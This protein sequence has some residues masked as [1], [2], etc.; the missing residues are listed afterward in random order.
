MLPFITQYMLFTHSIADSSKLQF[1]EMHVAFHDMAETIS[2]AAVSNVESF[3]F[4]RVKL[5]EVKASQMRQLTGIEMFSWNPLITASQRSNW[6]SFVARESGWYNESKEFVINDDTH[7]LTH[8]SYT[9]NET[10]PSDV[11]QI[12]EDGSSGPV[13]ESAALL[14]PMWQMS[15]PPFSP[16]FIN[17][18]IM[19]EAFV[20]T[21]LSVMQRTRD[22]IMSALDSTLE[23]LA[24]RAVTPHDHEA[25]HLLY[26]DALQKNISSFDHPHSVHLQPVF[27][28]LQD[29]GSPLAG[30]LSFVVP[31]D[32]YLSNLLPATVEGVVA[33]LSNT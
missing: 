6:S 5:F 18:N 7:L 16:S 32:K 33:V 4:V 3:P 29:P 1:Q 22:G 28:K 11:W 13:D 2:A 14:A 25:F 31:W 30:F 21:M 15:P 10:V 27:E 26:V 12:Q 17:Y 9:V 20:Q 19:E 24:I 23:R 8:S